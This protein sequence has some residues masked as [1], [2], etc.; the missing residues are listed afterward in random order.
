MVLGLNEGESIQIETVLFGSRSDD[1][2]IRAQK[3]RTE[4]G[5]FQV[6]IHPSRGAVVA[7]EEGEWFIEGPYTPRPKLTTGAGDNFNAGYC[8]GLLAGLAPEEC[9]VSGVC[10]SGFYVRNCHSPDRNEL[11]NFMNEWAEVNGGELP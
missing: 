8:N 4:L 7:A 2:T 10:T 11:L 5:L 3:I 9:L 1:L 6:V